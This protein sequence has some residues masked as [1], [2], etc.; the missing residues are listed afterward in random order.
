MY[1]LLRWLLN[2]FVLIVVANL[3]PGVSFSSFW[4]ALVT[5]A[6]LGLVNA[7]IR[8][9]MLILTLP[10]NILTLGLLTFFINALMFWLTSMIVKGF[11]IRDFA[12]AFWAALIY[13]L[14]ILL[15]NYLENPPS[16]TQTVKAKK[17]KK[18]R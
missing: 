7:I 6:I 16:Q 4:S 3:T 1:V 17:T 12:S 5:S 11:E 9:I 13:W 10:I 2:T 14:I 8:P 15:I 18:R